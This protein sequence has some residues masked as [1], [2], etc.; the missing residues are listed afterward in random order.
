MKR[1]V[2]LA[3]F[4]LFLCS[5]FCGTAQNTSSNA[6]KKA[7]LEKEIG[8]LER[9][10]KDNA[11]RSSNALA[12]LNLV[13]QKEQARKELIAESDKEISALDDSIRAYNRRIKIIRSRLD[14][15]TA[16]YRKLVRNAYK[17]RDARV[18]Y[19]YILT[20]QSIG[21]AVHRF[22]YLKSL[23]NQMN[24]Q[25]RKIKETKTELE[26]QR[27]KLNA[28]KEKEVALRNSRQKEL[29]KL[30]AEEARSKAL[31]A[32]LNKEKK[33]Y[34]NQLLTKKKQVTALN[35]EVEK[36]ITA[37]SG[38]PVN[39][40]L[41]GAFQS[42]KG[43]L[44]WPAEGPVLEHFG[45]HNHPVYKKIVM[46]FNNGIT[47]A[48]G[49]NTKIKAVFD[50]EVRKI[51]VMPGYGKC[52][53]VQH[54]DYFSFYCKLESISVKSGDKVKAGQALGIVDTIDG[55]TQLHFQI[56]KGVEPQDPE[57]WLKPL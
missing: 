6:D 1:T 13:R 25:G 50:G 16:Y 46:P 20:S 52:L 12:S 43:N 15:I 48:L 38:K 2:R 44:P 3:F 33:K 35:K 17:N 4:L 22:S 30:S 47:I 14:T 27:N 10:L 11:S 45:K 19:I 55:Q 34:Q 21:Q 32:Q 41:A 23:S 37:K 8:I 53:L 56:W 24:A 49:R 9:Q 28:L 5:P 26:A 36:V 7:R 51:I 31:V 40:K 39:R 54:G 18:W 29:D 57:K 42:N